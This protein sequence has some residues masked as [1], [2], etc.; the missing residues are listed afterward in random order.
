MMIM[1]TIIIHPPTTT[2]TNII[3]ILYLPQK[4]MDIVVMPLVHMEVIGKKK[5]ALKNMTSSLQILAAR[6]SITPILFFSNPLTVKQ[7]VVEEEAV[8]V[9]VFLNSM[10]LYFWELWPLLWLF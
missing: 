6:S 4:V 3:T 5:H 1:I 8:V 10:H 7:V 2:T 9:Q